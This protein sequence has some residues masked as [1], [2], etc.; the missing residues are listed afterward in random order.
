M[1]ARVALGRTFAA[2]GAGI[3]TVG[4]IDNSVEIATSSDIPPFT[5]SFVGK[6]RFDTNTFFGRMRKF[7]LA[8]DP[9]LLLYP[10]SIIYEK[11]AKIDAFKLKAERGE[12]LEL[13]S[14]LNRELWEAKRIVDSAVHPD[15]GEIVPRPFRMSGFLPFNGPICIGQIV[16]QSTGALGEC[17]RHFR[18]LPCATLLAPF[19]CCASRDRPR[20]PAAAQCSG[21]G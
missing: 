3:V 19:A 10:E 5:D 2:A 17:H 18:T 7:Q 6:S 15:T 16:S 1:A 13:T 8:C 4:I 14:A 21:T 9:T 11:K 20:A 12:P